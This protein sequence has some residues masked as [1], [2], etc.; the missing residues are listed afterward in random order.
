MLQFARFAAVRAAMA[1]FTLLLVSQWR[2][3]RLQSIC[4]VPAA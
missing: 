4:R 1:L 3:Q 2:W